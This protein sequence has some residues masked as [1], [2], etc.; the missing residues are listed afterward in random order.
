MGETTRRSTVFRSASDSRSWPRVCRWSSPW[1][2]KSIRTRSIDLP[3]SQPLLTNRPSTAPL[4]WSRYSERR[5]RNRRA[6]GYRH[7]T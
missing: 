1:R 4:W 5:I 7:L 6:V 3:G 2:T